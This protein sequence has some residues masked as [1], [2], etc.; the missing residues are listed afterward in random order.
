LPEYAVATKDER[1]PRYDNGYETRV[2][3]HLPPFFGELGLS[4]GEH[5]LEA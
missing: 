3:I 4:Q 2:R 1:S 5:I